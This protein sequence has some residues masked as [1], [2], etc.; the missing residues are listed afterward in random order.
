MAD[1]AVTV[2]GI[3][4]SV[5][6]MAERIPHGSAWRLVLGFRSSEPSRR[7]VW[8]TYPAEFTSRATLYAQAD[9]LSDEAM[10]S[11]FPKQLA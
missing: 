4:Y 2:N 10:A 3:R 11:L 6:V 7:S 5:A 9:R 1:R 8:A